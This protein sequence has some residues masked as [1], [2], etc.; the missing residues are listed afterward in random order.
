MPRKRKELPKI[1]N[2]K[3][4]SIAFL[5][6]DVMINSDG[7]AIHGY[8]VICQDPTCDHVGQFCNKP[9]EAIDRWNKMID[10]IECI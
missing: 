1:N 8:H 4:S 5:E 10:D 9:R 3:C 2:C 7:I 6:E